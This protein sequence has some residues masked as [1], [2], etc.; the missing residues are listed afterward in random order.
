MVQMKPLI[1]GDS[2]PSTEEHDWIEDMVGA[3][4]DPIIVYPDTGWEQDLPE[5]IRKRLPI[6]RLIH[7]M[8]QQKGE[9]PYDVACDTEALLYLFP[10]SLA[11]P[12][13]ELWTDI[14]CY[15]FNQVM[16]GMK[17]DIP[18][19]LKEHNKLSAYDMNELNRLKM[20][21][22]RKKLEA[23]KARRKRAK[24]ADSVKA[25]VA[26]DTEPAEGEQ[27]SLGF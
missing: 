13:G 8:R 9:I 20:F 22:H 18:D 12:M 10:R 2:V 11:A 16:G 4:T 14:Y 1:E 19:D 7:L 3:L 24:T 23:R 17:V 6:D 25:P 5:P 27:F 21:I 15:L 26:P